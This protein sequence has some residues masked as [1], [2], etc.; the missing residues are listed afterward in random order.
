MLSSAT[1]RIE[2]EVLENIS[3]IAARLHLDRG[4]FLRQLIMQ[5][6]E[7]KLLE[8][9]IEEYRKGKITITELAEKTKR[10]IWETMEILKQ[11]K[12]QSNVTLKDIKEASH[13]FG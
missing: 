12:I 13:V 10:T 9:G 1:L 11:K 3:K 8:M 5:S 7:E 4:T 6:Y 2:H